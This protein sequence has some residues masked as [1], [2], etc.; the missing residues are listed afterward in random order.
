MHSLLNAFLANIE[1]DMVDKEK[2]IAMTGLLCALIVLCI[3]CNMV[4]CHQVF[5]TLPT[6]G[7]SGNWGGSLISPIA[8]D[9]LKDSVLKYDR[10]ILKNI[11]SEMNKNPGLWKLSP[12]TVLAARSL[13]YRRR[14]SK[15]IMEES[16]HMCYLATAS[17]KTT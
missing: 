9:L 12:I 4:H 6:K 8:K 7:N 13:K 14:E 11:H 17:I 15:V 5:W 2:K 10:Y 3:E 16:W 1:L